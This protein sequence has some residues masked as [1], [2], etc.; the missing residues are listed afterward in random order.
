MF[1]RVA[2]GMRVLAAA[3][4]VRVG[5]SALLS[6]YLARR[7]GASA[8]GLWTFALAV[9]G[10]PLALV[11][12]G[13]TWIGTRDVATDPAAARALVRRVVGIRIVL[14][15]VGFAAIGMV[16]A[17]MPPDGPLRLVMLLA[18]TSLLTTS[19]T[20]DWVFY[21]LER[22][23]VVA[24]ANVT[25]V[26]I[27]ASA[28]MLLVH[29]SDQVWEVPVLQAAGE[30]AAA[31]ILWYAFLGWTAAVRPAAVRTSVAEL[32]RQAAP[33]TLAQLMRALTMW[34][35]V[36]IIGLFSSAA[37]VG[38]F[39][40]AQRVALLAGGLTTL[41]FY[42]Y[43][44]LAARASQQG[45]AAVGALVRHSLPRSAA[46]AV[47]FAALVAGFASPLVLRVFGEPYAPAIPVLRILVWTIPLSV[48]AG[49]LR[50]TL[51]A[52][53]LTSHDLAA[54]AAGAVATVGLN[55]ALVPLLGL[56]GGAIAM[57]AG[58]AALATAAT[59]LVVRQVA[60]VWR[61]G[62]ASPS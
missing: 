30:L 58:E 27:F 52:A 45:A 49:H 34:S 31:A 35:A 40:A 23:A 57:V 53:R 1:R 38:H 62:S 48:I 14:A 18:A 25:K 54:V 41:Y 60:P 46:A 16:A 51:I 6:V 47:L 2:G 19:I 3:E 43:V 13:L 22:R 29:R 44:P 10:Y 37:A 5:L 33:L 28:A 55:L 11:E 59:V 21:G 56:I 42:A 39:G 26:V 61:R 36:T 24:V 17:R 7:L 4:V 8:F 15:A 12:A 9:S 32:L 20:L 50:H